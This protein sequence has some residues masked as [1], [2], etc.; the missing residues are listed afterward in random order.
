MFFSCWFKNVVS[1]SVML[2]EGFF[3]KLARNL[4]HGFFGEFLARSWHFLAPPV[5]I[6]KKIYGVQVGLDFRDS[7]PLWA[8][9]S[10]DIESA[11][12]FDR[13]L[14]GISG[15]VWD[16]GCNGGIFSL[17]AASQ[18][19]RVVAFD[20]SPKA[21]NLLKK[22]AVRNGFDIATI[23]RAFAVKPFTY[24]PPTS[25]DTRNQPGQ[26]AGGA[27]ETSITFLEAEKQFGRPHFIKVDI[28]SAEI[29]FLKSGGFKDW[30]KTGRIPLLVEL[31]EQAF[32][33]LVWP[34]VPHLKFDD[35]H[36]FFNPPQIFGKT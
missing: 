35:N 36:V 16:V 8:T 5:T 33:D 32:W 1:P 19:N 4:R 6:W 15:N 7:L 29:D 20:I 18:K 30:I 34:D 27:R 22:S 10:T 24:T 3:F 26:A 31:H 25:A 21:I 9:N 13:M 28:E 23:T 14:I 17:Y 12:G 11:E 2:C